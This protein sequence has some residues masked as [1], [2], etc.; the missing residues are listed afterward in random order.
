MIFFKQR[1]LN[2]LRKKV[3]I[4]S[5]NRLTNPVSD[6]LVKKEINLY[7]KLAVVY[8]SLTKSK[9]FPFA[10]EMAIESYRLASEL[11]DSEASRIVGQRLLEKGQFWDGMTD[12]LYFDQVHD[13]YKKT[14]FD[15]AVLFLK[16]ASDKG[17]AIGK[18]LLGVAYVN[19]FGVE[20]DMD[21]G[22]K[23]IMESLD[24]E[25]AWPR[26]AQI[27]AELGLNKPDFFT[28]LMSMKVS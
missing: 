28:K 27:F 10:R 7:K 2:R 6:S 24:L 25:N 15:A 14:C 22:L 3:G 13:S 16:T 1:K 11:G 12:T 5:S 9:K 4:L 20:I 18:R 23:L 26:S 21:Q 17:D 8:D 19:G